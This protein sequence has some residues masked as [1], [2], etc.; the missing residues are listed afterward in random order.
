MTKTAL[1]GLPPNF[2]SYCDESTSTDHWLWSVEHRRWMCRKQRSYEYERKCNQKFP[3]ISRLNGYR[4]LDKK[5][6]LE[7]DL[8]LSYGRDL[9]SKPCFYCGITPS[10]GI[11]RKDSGIGHTVA[12]SIPACEIC[13]N[14]LGDLPMVVKNMLAKGLRESRDRGYFDTWTIPIK[15]NRRGK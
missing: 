2:C 8:T 5:R 4:Y 13:N 15:R 7:N 10:G 11:D 3:E 6:G 1:R 14:I 9:V 12:N